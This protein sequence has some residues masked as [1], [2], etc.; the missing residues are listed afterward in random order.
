VALSDVSIYK[1]LQEID[2]KN[3]EITS[4]KLDSNL[5]PSIH[6]ERTLDHFKRVEHQRIRVA[7]LL[8]MELQINLYYQVSLSQKD[9]FEVV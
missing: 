8:L 3:I 4:V 6:I 7:S 5:W 9:E 1:R 2:R